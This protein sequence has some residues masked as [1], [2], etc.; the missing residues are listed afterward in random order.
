MSGCE[1]KTRRSLLCIVRLVTD[2]VVVDAGLPSWFVANILC[3]IAKPPA[4]R[5][6]SEFT[7][8][9]LQ[10]ELNREI[11]LHTI[12]YLEPAAG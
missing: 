2:E 1:R 12:E 11:S 10:H 3:S 7:Q 9:Q 4:L 5:G 8:R 6:I